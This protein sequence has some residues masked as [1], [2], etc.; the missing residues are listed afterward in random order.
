MKIQKKEHIPV[1]NKHV[2]N[3]VVELGGNLCLNQR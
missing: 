2:M 3:N 1:V